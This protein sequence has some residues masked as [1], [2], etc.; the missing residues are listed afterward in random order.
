MQPIALLSSGLLCAGIASAGAKMVTTIAT[1]NI[2]EI[3]FFIKP[4]GKELDD[5]IKILMP[6]VGCCTLKTRTAI[7]GAQTEYRGRH[8]QRQTDRRQ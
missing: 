1:I 2:N 5:R 6:A 4:P 8:L 7:P 3:A